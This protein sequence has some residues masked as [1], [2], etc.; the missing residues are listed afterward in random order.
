MP[1]APRRRLLTKIEVEGLFGIFDHSIE[2][3]AE[4]DFVILHGINGVGKTTVL[5]IVKSALSGNTS[6]LLRLPFSRANLYFSDRTLLEV[7][8]VEDGRSSTTS[9]SLVSLEVKLFLRGKKAV[10]STKY[11]S[12]EDVVPEFVRRE[13]EAY[14]PLYF[15][16]PDLLF[17][18]RTGE[19]V[20]I[21]E[22]VDMLPQGAGIPPSR[23]SML[24]ELKSDDRLVDFWR[25]AEVHL[26]AT[27]RLIRPEGQRDQD[28]AWAGQS[29]RRPKGVGTSTVSY[30]SDDVK[31]QILD[32]LG[33]L[34]RISQRLEKTLIP[35]LIETAGETTELSELEIRRRYDEEQAVRKRLAEISILDEFG[36]EISLPAAIDE[37]ILR[38]MDI[39][40]RDS[41]EKFGAIDPVLT[42]FELLAR[43]LNEKFHFK[44]LQINRERG[45]VIKTITGESFGPEHLSSGEQ[46]E[47]V[48]LYDLLFQARSGGLVLIDEPEISLHVNWQKRFLSD[49]RE[50][51]KLTEHRFV[52]ATHSPQIVGAFRDRLVRLGGI[53]DG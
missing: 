7:T 14:T 9:R 45:F 29:K 25:S 28:Y 40:L 52:V 23:R 3:P 20:S 27:Q 37:H 34:A 32:A 49:L 17:D 6:R 35:R 4:W 46:H 2:F 15:I 38:M 43:I 1:P 8:R 51:S 33:L 39:F 24:K 19:E 50:V 31:R 36:P 48:L 42:K 22:A 10:I 41:E 13:I 21:G 16:G 26:I 12:A 5:D 47:L 11:N 44:S 18:P 30:F 53:D